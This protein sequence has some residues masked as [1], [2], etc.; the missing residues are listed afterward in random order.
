L[1]WEILGRGEALLVQ[2]SLPFQL[3]AQVTDL[4]LLAEPNEGAQRF[5]NYLALGLEAG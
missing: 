5:V 1:G 3:A 2:I 4:G